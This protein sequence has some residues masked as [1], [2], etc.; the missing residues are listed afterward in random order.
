[1][2]TKRSFKNG[3]IIGGSSLGVLV[4]VLL[5][6]CN[7]GKQSINTTSAS[8]T[9]QKA[10][11][12]RRRWIEPPSVIRTPQQSAKT[13]PGPSKKPENVPTTPDTSEQVPTLDKEDT[14]RSL[15]DSL[16][17]ADIEELQGLTIRDIL[18]DEELEKLDR[19]L[20][21]SLEEFVE[22][23]P[24]IVELKASISEIMVYTHNIVKQ[25]NWHHDREKYEEV[26]KNNDRISEMLKELQTLRG[27]ASDLEGFLQDS[28]FDSIGPERNKEWIRSLGEQIWWGTKDTVPDLQSK[29][30][31]EQ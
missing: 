16:S 27:R 28:D 12:T 31:E 7:A 24:Q 18:S 14:T 23:V 8:S 26:Q 25:Q 30:R 1:M 29:P 20:V 22:L 11:D 4:I 9:V 13:D 2:F 17:D 10:P 21:E 6:Q 15:V 3:L 19:E 5:L